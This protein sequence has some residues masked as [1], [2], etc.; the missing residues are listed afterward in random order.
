MRSIKLALKVH[1]DA[2]RRTRGVECHYYLKGQPEAIEFTLVPGRTSAE[3]VGEI[4]ASQSGRT[5]D[6]FELREHLEIKLGRM[7]AADDE[8]VELNERGEPARTWAVAKV[9][10]SR[11]YADHDTHNVVVRFHSVETKPRR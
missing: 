5:R 11:E 6:W 9:G 2:L 3:E 4:D 8:I 7:P 10:S 1:H